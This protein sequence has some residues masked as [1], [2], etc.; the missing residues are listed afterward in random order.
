MDGVVVDF[1]KEHGD[2]DGLNACSEN[3]GSCSLPKKCCFDNFRIHP[4]K[5]DFASDH[6]GRVEASWKITCFDAGIEGGLYLTSGLIA[7]FVVCWCKE[8]FKKPGYMQGVNLCLIFQENT[9]YGVVKDS[10]C[11]HRFMGFAERSFSSEKLKVWA[12]DAQACGENKYESGN[13]KNRQFIINHRFVKDKV[14]DLFKQNYGYCVTANGFSAGVLKGKKIPD[15]WCLEG[16][17]SENNSLTLSIVTEWSRG[18]SIKKSGG[19]NHR[20]EADPVSY[21][22]Q[23]NNIDSTCDNIG[24]DEPPS[25]LGINDP[26]IG[27]PPLAKVSI[28]PEIDWFWL[29]RQRDEMAGIMKKSGCFA[30]M[31]GLGIRVRKSKLPIAGNGP[32]ATKFIKKKSLISFYGGP[33]KE[34]SEK[35]RAGYKERFKSRS[36]HIV[37]LSRHRVIDGLKDVRY[38][39]YI[40]SMVNDISFEKYVTPGIKKKKLKVNAAFKQSEFNMALYAVEDIEVGDE[41]YTKYSPGHIENAINCG[42]MLPLKDMARL[43]ESGFFCDECGERFN[44]KWNLEK[45]QI[46]KHNHQE[47]YPCLKCGVICY[48]DYILKAHQENHKPFLRKRYIPRKKSSC[49][50]EC[51]LCEKELSSLQ[52]LESHFY[53]IHAKSKYFLCCY[54]GEILNSRQ[55]YSDHRKKDCQ[56]YKPVQCQVCQKVFSTVATLKIHDKNKHRPYEERK[57][58]CDHCSYRFNQKSVLRNHINETHKKLKPFECGQCHK[59]FS[60]KL[61]RDRHVDRNKCKR[62]SQAK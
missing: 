38:G 4:L 16:H 42:D 47:L 50:Y 15:Y 52:S 29:K 7:G 26:V 35:D 18:K 9:L 5:I 55:S 10:D 31:A 57:F 41:I 37:S 61:T 59:C 30:K 20:H 21:Y 1:E 51:Y 12:F 43:W 17:I 36:T 19:D 56:S 32:F 39:D 34:V 3:L 62:K 58:P 14:G 45:H 54:C 49:T 48:L 44:T 60:R 8:Y 33:L 27:A 46:F 22:T 25:L 11:T 6:S 13:D 53:A 24:D 23:V 2:D 40:A 28:N